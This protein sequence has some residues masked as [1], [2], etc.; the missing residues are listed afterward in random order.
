[1]TITQ[2]RFGCGHSQE[3]H[4]IGETPEERRQEQWECE[5]G[6]CWDCLIADLRTRALQ[7]VAS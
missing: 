2:I 4:M 7:T 3:V 1:M 5:H 6:K